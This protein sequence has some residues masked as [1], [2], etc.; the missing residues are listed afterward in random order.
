MRRIL[1]TFA[2][3]AL[4]TALAAAC[5]GDAGSSDDSGEPAETPEPTAVAGW[6]LTTAELCTLLTADEVS[7]AVGE[8]VTAEAQTFDGCHYAGATF[9]ARLT[10]TVFTA[11]EYEAYMPT[12][13][14][15]W[16]HEK[17]PGDAVLA[18][19]ADSLVMQAWFTAGGEAFELS[20]PDGLG[21][22]VVL[23]LIAATRG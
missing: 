19:T 8:T 15:S 23:A 10:E 5:G 3:L 17:E 11:Q 2:A 13:G 16:V 12:L 9:S 14:A 22:S 6:D 7:A 21:E 4:L 18:Y 20:I 1:V